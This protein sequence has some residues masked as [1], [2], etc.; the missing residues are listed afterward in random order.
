[1]STV[2]KQ[3]IFRVYGSNDGAFTKF[4]TLR[5]GDQVRVG[6]LTVKVSVKRNRGE[7]LMELEA[8]GPLGEQ[9]FIVPRED[10]VQI[11]KLK[12]EEK[13]GPRKLVVPPPSPIQI[14]PYRG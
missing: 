8:D 12:A 4:G 2:R 11:V 3:R 5:P 6:N 14:P 1:M 13:R 7:G 9:R 10:L